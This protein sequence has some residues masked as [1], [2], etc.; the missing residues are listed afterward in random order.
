MLELIEIDAGWE[1]AV[2]AALGESLTAVVVS[3]SIS[4]R[5]ALDALR[6]SDTSG[7]VIALG[8]QLSTRGPVSSGKPVRAHARSSND[9]VSALLDGLLG[10]AVRIDDLADAL[11]AAIVHPEAVI[12]T[13]TGDRFGINGWRI[14]SAGSGVTAAALEEAQGMQTLRRFGWNELTCPSRR[15]ATSWLRLDALRRS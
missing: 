6:S 15:R 13:G 9:E 12:V 11:D 8:S 10:G 4:A 14:G 7:A 3:D 5:S 1:A 2:E